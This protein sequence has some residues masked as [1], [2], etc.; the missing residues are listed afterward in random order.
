MKTDTKQQN[1]QSNIL[2]YEKYLIAALFMLFSS[3]SYNDQC[4]LS[5]ETTINNKKG[6]EIL[7][8]CDECGGEFHSVKPN[9]SIT[10]GGNV[11]VG[12][13]TGSGEYLLR[14]DCEMISIDCL[15]TCEYSVK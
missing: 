5:Y 14:P 8:R 7:V 13:D 15:S 11:V 6:K 1:S 9:K 10:F 12:I 3:C 2:T 4:E